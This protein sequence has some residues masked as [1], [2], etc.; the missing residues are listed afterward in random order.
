MKTTTQA[1]VIHL[2]KYSDKAA[3]LHV[4][5]K[6]FGRMAYIVYGINGKKRSS[7]LAATEPFSLVEIEVNHSA[8]R[9]IQTLVS[10]NMIYVPVS[11]L[12][13]IRRRTIAVFLSEILMR[14]LRHPEPDSTLFDFLS[15]AVH[16]L[17]STPYPENMHLKFLLKFTYFLGIMPSL[18]DRRKMLDIPSGLLVDSPISDISN[19]FSVEETNLLIDILSDE[20]V[21]ISRNVRQSLLTKLCRYYECHLTDFV[22]PKSLDILYEVYD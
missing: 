9:D 11:T 8:G 18:D 10:I 5:T 14:T 21:I 22:T 15:S 12:S 17:D 2:A 6:Q 20:N 16:Y 4:Y 1:I 3:I 13:D 19:C 7:L